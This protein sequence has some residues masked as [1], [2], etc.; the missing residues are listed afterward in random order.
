MAFLWDKYDDNFD[1]EIDM[2]EDDIKQY[3][4]L[5]FKAENIN[6]YNIFVFDIE[7]KLIR[8]WFES[9]H[10]FE[11]KVKGFLLPS[12]EFFILNNTGMIVINLGNIG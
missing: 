2:N 7:T 3:L 4:V 6:T 5:S 1:D 12:N 9:Y 10:M 11:N 8:L